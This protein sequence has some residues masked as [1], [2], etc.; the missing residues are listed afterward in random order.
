MADGV[1]SL[2][3]RVG[4]RGLK[5]YA[6]RASP[7]WYIRVRVLCFLRS[8]GLIV[9]LF[10]LFLIASSE[11]VGFVSRSRIPSVFFLVFCLCC[12]LLQL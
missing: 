1:A 10:R 2:Q 7:L 5:N 9:G 11:F 6:A 8:G 4:N 12:I 3:A